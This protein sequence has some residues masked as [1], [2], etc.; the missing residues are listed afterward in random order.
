MANARNRAAGPQSS[1]PTLEIKE[2]A[3]RLPSINTNTSLL[4]HFGE[5]KGFALHGSQSPG[6][7]FFSPQEFQLL[8]SG[9]IT[10]PLDPARG[11]SS[12]FRPPC[13]KPK[14]N[15]P[16][17]GILKRDLNSRVGDENVGYDTD[18]VDML[19][20]KWT[21]PPVTFMK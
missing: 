20:A 4:V 3:H 16:K 19:L 15:R 14:G 2:Q 10:P 13:F 1:R 9:F 18:V 8:P 17:E 7:S 11:A 5:Q 6:C 12:L 21:T